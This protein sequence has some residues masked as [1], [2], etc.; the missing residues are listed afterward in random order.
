MQ[1]ELKQNK[2]KKTKNK[3]TK[4]KQTNKQTNKKRE[5][6]YYNGLLTQFICRVMFT[7]LWDHGCRYGYNGMGTGASPACQDVTG[8]DPRASETRSM[9]TGTNFR[10]WI[11]MGTGIG[12]G[13]TS[14]QS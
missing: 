12:K 4:Q 13:I 14:L 5:G 9:G 10:I 11:S 6:K 8:M 3:N 7:Q 2:N 1:P